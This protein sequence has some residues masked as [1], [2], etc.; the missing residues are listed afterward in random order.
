MNTEPETIGNYAL[1]PIRKGL[2]QI[3]TTLNIIQ[4][5]TECMKRCIDALF[6]SIIYRTAKERAYLSSKKE[7]KK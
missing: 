1:D 5:G 3:I 2:N 6:Q 4:S 7:V